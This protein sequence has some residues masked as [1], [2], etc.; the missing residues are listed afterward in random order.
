M[1]MKLMKK[2]QKERD[3]DLVKFLGH[4]NTF[5]C[6]PFFRNWIFLIGARFLLKF[7]YRCSECL[8]SFDITPDLMLCPKCSINQKEDQPLIGVL[9]TECI[10][11]LPTSFDPIDFL[12]VERNFFPESPV[13]KT[14]LWKPKNLRDKLS[15]PNLFIKDDSSNPTGSLKDRASF[16]VAAFAKKHGIKNIVLASTGNAAS[17]MAGIG[18]A[19]D[20]STTIF[21]PKSA[22]P[23]KMIQSL[24]YGAN[25]ILVDGNYDK[26]YD[27]SLEYSKIKGGLNR[28]TAYNPLT[29]EGKKTVSLELFKELKKSPDYVFVP[30][31]DGVI[32]AGVYK[33]FRD[34]KKFNLL[35]KIPTIYAIQAE[36]SNAIYRAFNTGKFE[37]LPADT[38]ADSICVDIPRNG[39]YAIW[40]L[41]TFK[42]RFITVTNEEILR[43]QKELSSST[44]LFTE[45][46]GTA[47]FAGF[48]KVKNSLKK[49]ATIVL[50]ATGSGLKDTQTALKGVIP[51]QKAIKTIDEVL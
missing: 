17:S 18:A 2:K 23:A 11:S 27:L 4:A 51:P 41:K 12:P 31:G 1:V 45:P 36:T 35:D 21:L 33:G 38:I 8:A 37:P 10:G 26:A 9:E 24:Q 43:A 42:G 50:L 40:N 14:P 46:A 30:V 19:A 6:Y 5:K 28:N 22:P 44:G 7:K 47:S 49:N 29:I 3:H 16:L 15:T 20:I 13:G 32:I 34:L 48:L 25:V 39:Y